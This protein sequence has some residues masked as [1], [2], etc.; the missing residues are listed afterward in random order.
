MARLHTRLSFA[1]GF[2]ALV[3]AFAHTHTDARTTGEQ[4]YF[5]IP[6]GDATATIRQWAWQSG[7]QVLFDWPST[8]PYRTR[9]VDNRFG[10]LDALG[11]MLRDTPLTYAR[12]N[13]R[14]LAV[15]IGAQYCQPWQDPHSAPLP[16]CEPMPQNGAGG[17]L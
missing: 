12:V 4:R 2:L 10:A 11:A 1:A 5:F 6:S 7:L 16:P 14:T 3:L 17:E 15:I 8:A 13:A 9:A